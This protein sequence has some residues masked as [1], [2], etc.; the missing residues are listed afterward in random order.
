MQFVV[1]VRLFFAV[2]ERIGLLK[3]FRNSGQ[4]KWITAGIVYEGEEYE[5]VITET[6]EHFRHVPG[7]DTTDKKIKRVYALATTKDGGSFIADMPIADIEKRRNM[8]R[9]SRDD[10]PW[11]TWPREMMLKTAIRVLSKYLPM[12][13]DLDTLMQ[14]E[15]DADLGIERPNPAPVERLSTQAALD[16]FG[17][18]TT[19]EVLQTQTQPSDATDVPDLEL[20]TEQ[21]TAPISSREPGAAG[22]ADDPR[23]KTAQ[24]SSAASDPHYLAG[25]HARDVGVPRNKPPGEL[26]DPQR[27]QD[28][29]AWLAGYDSRG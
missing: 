11:K 17:G 14:R 27:K 25:Q 2:N 19:K 28:L 21:E 12:S 23:P 29:D 15:D 4:F 8:S 22:V 18:D 5:H 16:H 6:G 7:D 3:R 9:A 26:R 24:E 10:A 1:V 20:R 13:S